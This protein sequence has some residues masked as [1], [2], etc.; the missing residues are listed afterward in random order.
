[1]VYVLSEDLATDETK[2][3]QFGLELGMGK[4]RLWARIGELRPF[5]IYAASKGIPAKFLKKA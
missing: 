3:K 5:S 1:M 4:N 2:Q